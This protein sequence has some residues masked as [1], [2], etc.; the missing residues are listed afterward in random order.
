MDS[1]PLYGVKTREV[2]SSQGLLNKVSL[3]DFDTVYQRLADLQG[4][5]L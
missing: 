3:V 5:P 4:W 2:A 1:W